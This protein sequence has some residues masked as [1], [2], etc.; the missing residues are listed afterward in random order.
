MTCPAK[1]VTAMAFGGLFAAGSSAWGQGSLL[2]RQTPGT[3][4]SYIV[5][6]AE[7]D[8]TGAGTD[9]VSAR[10]ERRIPIR[11]SVSAGSG[12]TLQVTEGPLIVKGKS[13]GRARVKQ[14]AVDTGGSIHGASPAY[15]SVPFPPEGAKVGR[16]WRAGL[17]GPA[18]MPGGLTASYKLLGV[19]G[20]YAKVAFSIDVNGSCH[21]VGKGDLFVRA[22]D[23]YVDHGRATF[24]ISYVRPDPHD[25][26]KF[27]VNSHNVLTYS[28]DQ[29]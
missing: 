9:K 15:F 11:L 7:T 3:S 13:V 2:P 26:S 29:R 4:A 27:N 25:R 19:Q 21:V 5:S 24:D 10:I 12:K 18:P 22:A 8:Y 1:T 16:T 14:L 20:P 28:I 23:G 6:M 17:Y